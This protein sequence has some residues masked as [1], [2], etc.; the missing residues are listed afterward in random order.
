MARLKS[1][2]GHTFFCVNGAPILTFVMCVGDPVLLIVL[3][4]LHYYQPSSLYVHRQRVLLTLSDLRQ[5]RQVN[6]ELHLQ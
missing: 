6:V 5:L 1:Y 4:L 3:H 2:N